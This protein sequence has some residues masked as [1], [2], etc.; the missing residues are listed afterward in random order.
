MCLIV[1]DWRPGDEVPL[2]LAANRDETHDR[3]T[4]ALAPWEDAPSL[5]GG[6]DL[7]AGGTWLAAST[8][9]RLAAVTNVRAPLHPAPAAPPSRGALP[10]RA[11]THEAP[12][13]WL[14]ALA[15]GEA[16]AYAWFNLLYCDGNALWHL[17]HGPEATTL[18]SLS[19]GVHGVS[20]ATLDTPWPKLERA[21]EGFAHALAQTS[22]EAHTWA[23]MRDTRPAPADRLPD[24]GVGLEMERFLSPIFIRGQRYGTR[25]TTLVEW[26]RD[27][28]VLQEARFGPDARR[29]GDSEQRLALSTP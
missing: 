1:F 15:A 20:N 21:R 2:R 17:H 11:L 14:E 22:W 4:R 28:I 12:G 24:T 13:E 7:Q 19:P 26:R 23:L 10:C 27:A 8:A 16:A 9:G 29:D 5:V 3:P 25:A 18:T 6:R